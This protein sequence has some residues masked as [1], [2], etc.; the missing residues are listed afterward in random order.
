MTAHCRQKGFTLV[1][2]LVAVLLLAMISAMIYSILSVAIRTSAKGEKMVLAMDRDLGILALL[3]S[4]I[5]SAWH[6]PQINQTMISA[7]GDTLRLITRRP[8]IHRNAEP[9]L[10]IYRFNPGDRTIYYLEIKD[11]FNTEYDDAFRPDFDEMTPLLTVRN[12]FSFH[13]DEQEITVAV[14]FNNTEFLFHPRSTN[15]LEIFQ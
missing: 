12:D 2:L 5:T 10:A 6:D 14:E 8:I 7:D 15:L 9:V 3:D 1:E 13:F 11:Y 4:Q